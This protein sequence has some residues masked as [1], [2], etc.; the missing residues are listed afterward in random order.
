MDNHKVA[1][2]AEASEEEDAAIQVEVEAKRDKLTHEVSED[3]VVSIGIVM[4]QERK[5][6]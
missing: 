4:Y 1:K 5:A 3:L 2:D 6:C